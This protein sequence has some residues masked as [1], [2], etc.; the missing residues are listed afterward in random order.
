MN[1]RKLLIVIGVVWLVLMLVLIMLYKFWY[2]FYVCPLM[3][4]I[5]EC[6][7][8]GIS[9]NDLKM[10]LIYGLPSWI[11]FLIATLIKSKKRKR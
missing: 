5:G 7:G 2:L 3:K 11:L 4:C 6:P 8:C 10:F 9:I 1:W